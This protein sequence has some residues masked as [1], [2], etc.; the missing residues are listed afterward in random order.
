MSGAYQATP[1][2]DKD[3]RHADTTAAR[4]MLAAV[5]VR[6]GNAGG[7]YAPKRVARG[8]RLR[9]RTMQ[10]TQEGFYA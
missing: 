8:P 7:R 3:H 9:L 2:V 10:P 5:C 6:G 4:R 1:E